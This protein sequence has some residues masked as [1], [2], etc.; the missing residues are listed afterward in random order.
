MNNCKLLFT[1][2]V[3]FDYCLL[4]ALAEN[5]YY[6]VSILRN[7]N[8]KEYDNESNQVKKDIDKLVNDRMNDIYD[9]ILENK[10]TYILENDTTDEKLIE[11][12]TNHYFP[13]KK[14]R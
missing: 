6:I 14:K 12:T 3:L 10:D 7:K 2:I 4:K 13:T 1:I 5:N 8:D 9:I 11:L